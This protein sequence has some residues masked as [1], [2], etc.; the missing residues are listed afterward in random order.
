MAT[1]IEQNI[2]T[3]LGNLTFQLLVANTQLG[4]A[5]EQLQAAQAELSALKA[6]PKSE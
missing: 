2:Q 5:Q 4:Q 3:L 1:T 6:Q